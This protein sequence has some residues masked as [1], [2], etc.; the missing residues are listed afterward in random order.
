MPVYGNSGVKQRELEVSEGP[1]VGEDDGDG[2]EG[3]EGS[4]WDGLPARDDAKGEEADDDYAAGEDAEDEGLVGGLEAE[5]GADKD[6]ELDV[7]EAEAAAGED[8]KHEECRAGNA[9]RDETAEDIAAG[10]DE[11]GEEGEQGPGVGN[12]VRDAELDEVSAGAEKEREDESGYG[13]GL[14]CIEAP[15]GDGHED[16]R[17]GGDAVTDAAGPGADLPG[18]GPDLGAGMLLGR[19]VL[20]RGERSVVGLVIVGDGEE[21]DGAIEEEGHGEAG[22]EEPERGHVGIIGEKSHKR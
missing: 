14:R 4:V 19:G 2:S 13:D 11:G 12:D 16:R 15:A 17:E 1:A 7:A 22:E 8:G 20:R 5:A 21:D 3:E 10:Q 18:Q 6:R 9:G